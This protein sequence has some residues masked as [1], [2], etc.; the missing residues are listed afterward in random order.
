MSLLRSQLLRLVLDGVPAKGTQFRE[1]GRVFRIGR[2]ETGRSE[3]T[4]AGERQR[5]GGE[6]IEVTL[7][8][9][10]RKIGLERI[11]GKWDAVGKAIDSRR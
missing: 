1:Y 10:L 8:A 5:S 7:T 6:S 3:R 4:E 11:I 9:D 2:L